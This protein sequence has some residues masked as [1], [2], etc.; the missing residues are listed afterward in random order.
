MERRRNRPEKYNRELVHKTVRAMDKIS[1]V[2]WETVWGLAVAA[3]VR[4]FCCVGSSQARTT[5]SCCLD[6]H[7][8][9]FSAF[10]LAVCICM[11]LHRP[12]ACVCMIHV[13][14]LPLSVLLSVA[15]QHTGHFN[16]AGAREEAGTVLSGPHGKGQ[17]TDAGCSA[18]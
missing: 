13:L 5:T 2:G 4:S 6:S 10:C 8:T 15:S 16:S 9:Q 12:R 14:D 3:G 11:R 7:R 17:G 1:E 18:G